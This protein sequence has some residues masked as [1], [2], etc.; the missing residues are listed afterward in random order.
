MIEQILFIVYLRHL[1]SMRK[2]KQKHIH[3]KIR[4]K[5]NPEI[6]L[7][8]LEKYNTDETSA[9]FFEQVVVPCKVYNDQIG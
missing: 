5:Q 1:K 4:K 7:I 3:R 9:Q 8:S 2:K 6:K